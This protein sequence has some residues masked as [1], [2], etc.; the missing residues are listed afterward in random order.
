[1]GGRAEA[2]SGMEIDLRFE[3]TEKGGRYLMTMPNGELSR[4]SYI[5]AGPGTI[6]A[7]STFV[8]VPYRGDGVAEALVERLM[9]DARA[10]GFKVIP[11]CW[12]VADEIR[13]RAPE[14]DD[15]RA[16]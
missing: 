16:G 8:P 9:T 3:E 11:A 10:Q 13:R 4:I 6:I 2:V 14:W 5:R 15:L 1:M 7:D 12:F